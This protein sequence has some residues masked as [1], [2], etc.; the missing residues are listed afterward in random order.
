M[1]W[2]GVNSI[3]YSILQLFYLY[4]SFSVFDI[5]LVMN[6]EKIWLLE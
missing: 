6:E 1:I 2:F 4:L 3:F 5:T